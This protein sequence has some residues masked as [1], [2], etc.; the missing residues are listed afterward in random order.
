V[1]ST[2]AAAAATVH[3]SG[4]RIAAIRRHGDAALIGRSPRAGVDTE[5][6]AVASSVAT[7]RRLFSAA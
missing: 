6:G 5:P 4:T 2:A 7:S 1:S 3:G